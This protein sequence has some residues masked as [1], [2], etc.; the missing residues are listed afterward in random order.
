MILRLPDQLELAQRIRFEQLGL[1]RQPLL[2]QRHD[3]DQGFNSTGGS[4]QMADA[5]FRGAD[6]KPANGTVCP[7]LIAAASAL[8]L[9]G[10]PVP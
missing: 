4:E 7:A 9:R 3:A 8:S 10:V 2:A 5:C 6:A 1:R